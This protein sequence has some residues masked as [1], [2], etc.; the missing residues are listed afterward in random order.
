MRANATRPESATSP[1]VG[2]QTGVFGA[3]MQVELLNDGSVTP[4]LS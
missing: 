3:R 1:S 2:V 4:V